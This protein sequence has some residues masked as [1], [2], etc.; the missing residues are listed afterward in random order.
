VRGNTFTPEFCQR[1]SHI[2]QSGF[3]RKLCPSSS[4]VSVISFKR[5][6][7]DIWCRLSAIRPNVARDMAE[8]VV[9][10]VGQLP[11]QDRPV[12]PKKDA[13]PQG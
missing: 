3:R 12:K 6:R 13:P 7:R 11:C 2:R 8:E 10:V 9:R 5:A 1:S 4:S